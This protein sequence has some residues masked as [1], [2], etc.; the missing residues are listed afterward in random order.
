M[1]Q[2]GMQGKSASSLS[3]GQ[4]AV[5]LTAVIVAV[6]LSLSGAIFAVIGL[7]S[8]SR[9]LVLLGIVVGNAAGLWL[10]KRALRDEDAWLAAFWLVSP[11]LAVLMLA[12]MFGG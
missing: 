4:S 7:E 5:T 2:Q 9:V 3:F 11:M 10:A 12:S 1:K 8:Y 6:L